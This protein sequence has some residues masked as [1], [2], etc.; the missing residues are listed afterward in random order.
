MIKI[1]QLLTF[2]LLLSVSAFSQGFLRTDGTKIINDDGEYIL[3]GIGTGNWLIQEGYMMQSTSAGVNT[4][5]QFHDKL[6]ETMGQENTDKFYDT[7]IENHFRK[8]DLDSMKTWGFNSVRVALHYKWFTLPI[9][10]E[11]T[12]ANGELTNTW[13][14]KGFEVTD[15][16]LSWCAQNEMYLILDMHGA[17]GGQGKDANISDYDTDLPSLWESEN[18]KKKLENLWIKLADRY[19]DSP[20]IAGYDLFNE[21]NWAFTDKSSP[22]GCGCENNDPIWELHER[23][24]NAV[25]TVD[26]NH[27]VFISGNCW[28]NNYESLSKHSLKDADDNMVI[29]FHKYWNNNN[30]DV[31]NGW[32][33]MREE[34]GL[35]LWMSESGENSNTWFSDSIMLYEKNKIGWSWW[36]VKKSR[37]NN[38]LKV[39]TP[40]SYSA[41]ITSWE[42]KAPLSKEETFAAVMDYAES[43]KTENCVIAPDVIYAMTGQLDN[44][45]TKPFKVHTTNAPILFADYDLGRDGYAYY[46][47]IS[48]DYHIDNGGDWMIWNNGK[49][50]RNDGVDITTYNQQPIVSWTEEEEWMQYTFNVSK[51]GKYTLEIQSS[52]TDNE[53]ILQLIINDK[54]VV[55]NILLPKTGDFEKYTTTSIKK[56]ILPS[57]TVKVKFKIIK[58]NVNLLDFKFNK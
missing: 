9:E 7:W 2:C 30:S 35:P 55:E 41:L 54:V 56:V 22:N 16:L 23:L 50:Y 5:T 46:D 48:A 45:N 28:G 39:V 52:A 11:D 32:L 24:I 17:P 21:P 36:P 27:I 33:K 20:W 57:G 38:I 15:S 1:L 8:T 14:N 51:K 19:K 29:T 3:R 26:K 58:G 10:E 47:K 53:G 31:L 43:H 12:L 6:V 4:H 40:A 34:Y 44:Y 49:F 13:I 18:N 37:T 42:N 25:R